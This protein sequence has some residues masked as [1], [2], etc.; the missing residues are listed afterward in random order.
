VYLT[1]PPGRPRRALVIRDVAGEDLQ[2]PEIDRHLFSFFAR[3]DGVVFMVDPMQVRTIALQLAGK[4][5][6]Q[7]A[8]SD[9]PLTVLANLASLRAGISSGEVV[10][11]ALTLA[12]FDALQALAGVEG[13]PLQSA[14]RNQGA[15]YLQ[16]P[17]MQSWGYDDE[18]GALLD[19]ELRSLVASINGGSLLTH[20]EHAFPVVRCFAVSAL[21]HHPDA[22]RIGRSGITPFRCLDPLKWILS[23][24]AA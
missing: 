22:S 11:L 20:A 3:A 18:D 17:S 21:G 9:D 23:G 14:M 13:S 15:S 24:A 6:W 2:K 8:H 16:D 4:L 19:A 5:M 12:K 10:P 7:G 1:S